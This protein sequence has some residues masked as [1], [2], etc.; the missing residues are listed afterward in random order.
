MESSNT[1]DNHE[2]NVRRSFNNAGFEAFCME[3]GTWKPVQDLVFALPPTSASLAYTSSHPFSGTPNNDHTTLSDSPLCP[4]NLQ[5]VRIQAN[6]WLWIQY[7]HRNSNQ[8]PVSLSNNATTMAML[9]EM[10]QCM[11]NFKQDCWERLRLHQSWY[12]ASR[13]KFCAH[14]DTSCG[15][16]ITREW[17]LASNHSVDF[18]DSFITQYL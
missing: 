12:P 13:R 16:S 15:G 18:P 17:P 7:F 10:N 6:I 4:Q 9:I 11:E 8:Y 14:H 3:V 2:T 1:W 5:F